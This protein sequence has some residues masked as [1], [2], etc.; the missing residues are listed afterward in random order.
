MDDDVHVDAVVVGSRLAQ[1]IAR[2]AQLVQDLFEPQLVGLVHDDEKHFIVR[3]KLAVFQTDRLLQREQL[4]NAEISPVV[5][6]E[7]TLH[8]GIVSHRPGRSQ[9][10]DFFN[11]GNANKSHFVFYSLGQ[12]AVRILAARIARPV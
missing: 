5:L 9:S 10:A 4:V 1:D 2:R 6:I 3:L 12:T 11:R 7:R 8:P